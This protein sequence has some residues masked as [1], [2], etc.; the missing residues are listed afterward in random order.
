[1]SP[2]KP[3]NSF[4]TWL[5]LSWL[6]VV[7]LVCSQEINWYSTDNGGGVSSHN[8]LQVLGVVGQID[9][10]RMEGGNITLAGGYIP[11]PAD[12]IFKNEFD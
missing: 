12:L 1:M 2:L 11:L 7:G 8:D 6:L 4:K 9:T 10:V 5:G 3:N